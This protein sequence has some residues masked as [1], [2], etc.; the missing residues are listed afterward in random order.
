M[1]EKGDKSHKEMQ[2]KAGKAAALQNSSGINCL[3]MADNRKASSSRAGLQMMIDY[4]P[5][6]TVQRREIE[7]SFDTPVQRQGP[8][9][10]EELMQGKFT[11]Q[12]AELEDE[13]LIQGKFAAQRSENKTGLPDD[14]KAGIEDLSGLS[15]DNVRVYS[16]SAKPAAVGAHAYTQG[17]DIHMAPGQMKHL[18]HEAWHVV[19][20]MQ[21]RVKPTM[22]M[23]GKSINNDNSLEKEADVKGGAA[24]Q[25]SMKGLQGEP[26]AHTGSGETN[27]RVIPLFTSTVKPVFIR[28]VKGDYIIQRNGDGGGVGKNILKG[29]LLTL[30]ALPDILNVARRIRQK[31][32]E[33]EFKVKISGGLIP[34]SHLMISR[35]DQ[36]L[37]SL[38][39]EHLTKNSKLQVIE[40]DQPFEFTGVAY[41]DEEGERIK[42]GRLH[43]PACI[44][45]GLDKGSDTVLSLL[46][47]IRMK[48]L[49][50]ISNREE[51]EALYHDAGIVPDLTVMGEGQEGKLFDW[52]LRHEIG[53]SIDAEIGWTMRREY[54]DPIFGGWHLLWA[55]NEIVKL[56]LIDEGVD[57]N[58]LS[59][60]TK[61]AFVEAGQVPG[62][63]KIPDGRWDEPRN[64]YEAGVGGRLKNAYKRIRIA[65]THPWLHSHGG[66]PAN[67]IEGRIYQKSYE[68][69]YNGGQWMSYI[70]E[71][72]KNKVSN[73][74]FSCPTEWFAEAYAAYY[75][76]DKEKNKLDD[77]VLDWFE[78]D[79]PKEFRDKEEKD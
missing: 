62:G 56:F 50:G 44:F 12:R 31:L 32:L 25:A 46:D 33:K 55:S 59:L 51:I 16:N 30:L 5:R 40:G 79:L 71:A 64:A 49:E 24:I 57:Y 26:T 36:V 58:R 15:L 73:Y 20:Q 37:R 69:P 1:K 4:S 27:S 19:Q 63:Y 42:L 72:R 3:Q 29:T 10:E 61:R 18:P 76:P 35:I 45:L 2:S 17:T 11:V 22:R 13:E 47:R 14:L 53:H 23:K 9:E 8:E 48:D 66:A 41:F 38:P 67:R 6:I 74:Q 65:V 39:K 7:R 34:F 60:D 77:W 28:K 68:P 52:Q 54:E 43:I 75:G 21:G 78:N 70:D